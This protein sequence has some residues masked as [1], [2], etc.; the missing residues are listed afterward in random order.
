MTPLQNLYNAFLARV[1]SDEWILPDD[2][3]LARQDWLQLFYIAAFR[4]KFPRISLEVD[5]GEQNFINDVTNDE[6]QL[7]AIYMK[8]EWVKRCVSS[9]E[10]VRA[11]YTNKDFSQANYLDKLIKLSEQLDVECRKET[12]GYGRAPNHRPYAYGIFAGGAKNGN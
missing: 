8:H 12:S 1:T 5:A 2:I 11:I 3:V 10:Q 6:I 9:W 7:L 4:F